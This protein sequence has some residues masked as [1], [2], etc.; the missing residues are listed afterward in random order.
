MS[1][2]IDIDD[3]YGGGS[4]VIVWRSEASH[5]AKAKPWEQN[6]PKPLSGS[7]SLLGTWGITGYL[8]RT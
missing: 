5:V 6:K 1:T 2:P 4:D 7:S 3:D 8:R